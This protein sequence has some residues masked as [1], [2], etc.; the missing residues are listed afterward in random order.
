MIHVFYHYNNGVS[1]RASHHKSFTTRAGAN[2]WAFF[3]GK[4]YPNF[5]L[6]EVF[7]T[8]ETK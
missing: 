5:Q 7:E 1:R 4:K 6:D 2:R 3:M 8:P